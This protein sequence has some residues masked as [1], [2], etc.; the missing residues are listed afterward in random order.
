MGHPVLL[1]CLVCTLVGC[2]LAK[3]R[4]K[5]TL[6]QPIPPP[7]PIQ[8][9]KIFTI[10]ESAQ[11]LPEMRHTSMQV[12]RDLAQKRHLQFDDGGIAIPFNVPKIYSL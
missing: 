4:R 2:L 3:R 8:E 9:K 1:T 10:D 6:V 11:T 5:R 12:E 7:P